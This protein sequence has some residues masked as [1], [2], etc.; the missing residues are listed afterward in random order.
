MCNQARF[1]MF[2]GHLTYRYS[3]DI[4]INCTTS[5]AC[6][7]HG[8]YISLK[9]SYIYNKGH[10]IRISRWCGSAYVGSCIMFDHELCTE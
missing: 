8:V 10:Q 5:H 3:C 7:V 6:S 4:T 2:S 1:K 9:S